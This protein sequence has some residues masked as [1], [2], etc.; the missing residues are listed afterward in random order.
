MAEI[1]LKVVRDKN[2]LKYIPI[3]RK[4]TNKTISEIKDS[5]VN[6][7]YIYICN[8]NE[9][10]ELKN[11]NKLVNLLLEKGAIIELYEENRLVDIEF[12]QNIIDSHFGTEEYQQEVD[13]KLLE[14]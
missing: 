7:N 13:D 12:L 14:E 3:V 8:L 6:N 9:I 10:D 11:M 4:I 5:L 2:E 1:K